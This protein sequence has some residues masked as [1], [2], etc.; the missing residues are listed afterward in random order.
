MDTVK[1]DMWFSKSIIDYTKDELVE[2]IGQLRIE[3]QRIKEEHFNSSHLKWMDA[4][5]AV[6]N[7]N[8]C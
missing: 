1:S 6:A 5:V 4:M 2:I 3:N 7:K 8:C